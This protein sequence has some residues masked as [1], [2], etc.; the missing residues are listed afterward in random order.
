MEKIFFTSESVTEGHPDKVCDQISD[1][2][3]DAALKAD[4]NSRVAIETFIKTGFVVIGGELTTKAE[5]INVQKIARDTLINI[6]YDNGDVGFNGHNCGVLESISEQSHDI[7]VGVNHHG[8]GDQGMMFGYAC[9]ETEELM[10]LPISLAHKL[11]Y[12]LSEVRK[13]GTI[14]YI[15]PDGKS[16]VTVEYDDNKPVRIEA[17]VVSSHHRKNISQTQLHKDIK[18]HV[19]KPVCGTLMDERTKIHINPTGAFTEGGPVA[20]AGLTGR[21]IIVDTYGGFGRHGGGAFSGKDATKV[22]RSAAYMARYIAKNLVAAGLCRRC[23]VQL[24]YAIGEAEPVSLFVDT[25]GTGKISNTRLSKII[26]KEFPLT[27]FG[28]IKHLD[29]KKPIY[30]PTAAYGHFGR[31]DFSWEKTNKVEVLKK[32]L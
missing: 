25:F 24:A 17:I 2:V 21:K 27:P 13:N 5:Y 11:A 32:Y 28:I 8:A 16:Q 19:I 30:L 3:L 26:R 14:D 6:G 7:S 20:D 4:P 29:L 31:N 10:P 23:E 1:A 15:F 22:D 12:R 18:E 9:D